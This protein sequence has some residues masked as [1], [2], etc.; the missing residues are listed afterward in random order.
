MITVILFSL[1]LWNFL[2][3]INHI[4]KIST[5]S[6]KIEPIRICRIF[7]WPLAK[8]YFWTTFE[9][10]KSANLTGKLEAIYNELFQHMVKLEEEKY[11][12]NQAVMAKDAEVCENLLARQCFS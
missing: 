4:P 11:D 1:V 2:A 3:T 7:H 10:L 6:E 8:P 12:I 5:K 9:S